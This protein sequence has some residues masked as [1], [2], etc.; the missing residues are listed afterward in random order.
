MQTQVYLI[1]KPTC[2]LPWCVCVCV[3]INLPYEKQV[4]RCR[5]L[6]CTIEKS[7]ADVYKGA[8]DKF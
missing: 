3:V 2:S 5:L 8:L 4:L 7:T 6:K 1:P